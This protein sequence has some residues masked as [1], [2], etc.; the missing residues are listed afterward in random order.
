MLPRLYYIASNHKDHNH[1]ELVKNACNEGVQ[2]IQLRMKEMSDNAKLETAISC[3]E[4]CEQFEGV[5]LI[6]NDDVHITEK[7]QAAGIHLGRQDT[8]VF[9]AKKTLGNKF[10][11]GG[12]ANTMEDCQELI[13]QQVDY[14]GLGPFRFTETKKNLSPILGT[15]GYSKVISQIGTSTP[16]YA[17]GGIQLSDIT[18]LMKTGIHGIAISSLISNDFKNIKK[19]QSLLN[20]A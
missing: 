4:I 6:I 10:I 7:I 17:I 12:T 3:I 11:F 1:A 20:A 16:I 9:Q 14:I 15:E 8:P 5:Q 2:L 13:Q 18:E 19:I